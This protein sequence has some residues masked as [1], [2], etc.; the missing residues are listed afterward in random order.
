MNKVLLISI[1]VSLLLLSACSFGGKRTETN[2]YVLDYQPSTEMPEL[3]MNTSNGKILHV[4]NTSVNRTYNRNQ[5]VEKENFYRVQ[6]LFNELWANRLADAV[7]NI[8]SRRLSAYN[9]FGNVTRTMGDTNPNY[10]LETSIQNI[11]KI[12]GTTPRAFLRMEFVLRDSTGDKVLLV[13]RNERYED[14]NDDS[15]VYLVQVYNNM[16][17]EETNLFA[18]K[19]ISYFSGR[20]ISRQ[21]SEYTNSLSA[22]EKYYFESIADME[23]HLVYGE[24]V[25][26]TKYPT[27]NSI[28]YKVERLDSLNTTISDEVG[29]FNTP[30]ILL[31]GRYRVITGHNED[32]KEIV[33]VFP[34]QRTV[35]NRVWSELKVRIMDSSQNRV[36]QLYRIWLQN[37]NEY[38]YR[39]IGQDVSLGDDEHGIDDRIWLLPEGKY[40]LTLGGS[41]WSDLRDFATICLNEGD[42]Q[43]LTVIV[44][45]DLSGG[46]LMVGAGVLSDDFGFDTAQ[47]HKGAVHINFN[48]T[49]NNKVDEADPTYSLTLSSKFDNTIDHEFRPFHYNLRSIYDL[50]AIFSKDIDLRF[51]RDTYNL[52]NTLMLYPWTRERKILGKFA[53]YGRADLSTH[54]MDEYTYFSANK[55]YILLD[56]EGNETE[57][58]LDQDRL[59]SKVALYPLRMKEGAGITYRFALSPTTALTLRGGYGWQQD[60]NKKSYSSPSN[61]VEDGVSYDVYQESPDKKSK[62]LESI[63]IFSAG[64]ILNFVSVN[65]IFEVL[66]PFDKSTSKPRFENEN[67]FNFRIYRNISLDLEMNLSYDESEKDWLVYDYSTYLRL[68]LFY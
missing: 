7:P 44:N 50:R 32:I 51:D 66:F 52:K 23:S 38:G 48:A 36:R 22:P 28:T 10:Y 42:S 60:L 27:T 29:E 59:R 39:N 13:H 35:V 41:N 12:V 21:R 53:F 55:N 25:L 6:F 64:N 58:A 9:I 26:R 54:F 43:V 57:R 16:I 62:G 63:L 4:F 30:K 40:M 56:D 2:Y 17:M 67:T 61:I 31:P 65:S 45:T 34:R 15:Y 1:A 8:I 3:K 49:S 24:L 18:A 5:L 46:N 37:E 11:E 20:P 68:S 19:C 14:L 47:F 33:E